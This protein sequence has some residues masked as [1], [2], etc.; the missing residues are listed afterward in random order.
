M[1]S[2]EIQLELI[3]SKKTEKKKLNNKVIAKII[4]IS[5]AAIALI[6]IFLN[7]YFLNTIRSIKVIGNDFLKEE[8]VIEQAN[9][10]LGDRFFIVNSYRI[11][12]KLIKDEKINDCKVTLNKHHQLVIEIEEN[13]MVGYFVDDDQM[14]KLILADGKVIDFNASF[15]KNITLLPLIVEYQEDFTA[16]LAT[17]LGMLKPEVLTHISEVNHISFTYDKNMVKLT[18]DE[19]YY[20][21]SSLSGLPYVNYYFDIISQDTNKNKGCLMIVEDEKK[22]LIMDCATLESYRNDLD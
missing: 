14:N 8:Y 20:V 10:E 21:Y 1:E 6:V 22:A 19:G 2:G 17:R 4:A 7:A 12:D 3:G 11:A 16:A 15:V 9:V 5:V 18:T 13:Q